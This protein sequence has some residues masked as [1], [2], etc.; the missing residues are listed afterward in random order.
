MW[1][2]LLG[3]ISLLSGQIDCELNC[4]L[5][6]DKK[7]YDL[8]VEDLSSR[9]HL[10]HMNWDLLETRTPLSATNSLTPAK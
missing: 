3:N 2:F 6:K 10:C 8:P 5:F 7:T 9:S 1:I 4:N